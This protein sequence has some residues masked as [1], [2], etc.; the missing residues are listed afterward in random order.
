MSVAVKK[1]IVIPVMPLP[2][3]MPDMWEDDAVDDGMLDIAMVED[4]MSILR[5]ESVVSFGIKEIRARLQ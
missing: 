1:T 4:A 5:V 3:S 2:I